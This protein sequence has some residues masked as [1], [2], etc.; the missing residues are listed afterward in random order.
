MT[1]PRAVY[2]TLVLAGTLA[3]PAVAASQAYRL[4]PESGEVAFRAYGMGLLPI[5]GA[6][7]RFR[8]TLTLDS[9]SPA[10]CA[11]S[12]KA[13]AASLRMPQPGMTADALGPDLLDVT[14]F[15]DFAFDGRC[16]G[17]TLRGTLLLHGVSRPLALQVAVQD[18]R[19]MATGTMQ[20]AEWGMG[21]RP[22]L[23]GPTVRLRV[24]AVLPP[25]FAVAP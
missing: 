22:L 24:T 4:T 17:T 19:W 20:R 10:A 12:L 3:P 15:P 11:I 5:D 6:F 13:D 21:A 7:T 1:P 16:D 25:G 2:I 14:R 23:A 18:G 9:A 8:G